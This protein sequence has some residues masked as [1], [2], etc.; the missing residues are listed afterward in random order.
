MKYS[1]LKLDLNLSLELRNQFVEGNEK[2]YEIIYKLYAKEMYAFGLSICENRE[3]I[4]DAIHDVFIEIYS[5][6][7][8]LKKVSNFNLYFIISFRNRLFYLINK[9]KRYADFDAEKLENYEEKNHEEIWIE[10][11]NENEKMKI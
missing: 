5:R 9:S 1:E 10:N 8:L 4:E 2:A 6:K 3:I 7:E 11:E